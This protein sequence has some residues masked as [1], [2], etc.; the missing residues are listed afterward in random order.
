MFARCLAIVVLL[1][2]SAW[3]APWLADAR[4]L[5][6]LVAEPAPA[7]LPSP[8]PGARIYDSWGFE[9]DGGKR[10]HE[11]IDIFAPRGT[12]VVATTRGRITRIGTNALGGKVVWVLGPGRQLH[13]Y[14]HLDEI[15]ARAAGDW[16]TPGELLGRVGNTGNARGGPTHLHYGIY[17]AGGAI[18]PYP[19]LAPVL[20][21][22]Q[23][24]R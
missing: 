9:R 13:Y 7:H 19:Q 18:N 4:R 23:S 14:A 22:R 20:P 12:P 21:L 5:A 10:R 24:V 6:Q 8:V 2:A 11:G 16:V 17:A 3:L 15:A 1:A